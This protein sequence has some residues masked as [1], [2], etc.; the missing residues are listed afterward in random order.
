MKTKL[1]LLLAIALTI[2]IYSFAQAPANDEC[3]GAIS[4]TQNDSCITT[5]GDIDGATE[6][7]WPYC[8]GGI[9]N[10]VWYSFVATTTDPTIQVTGSGDF[11]PVIEMFDTCDGTFL[12]C[13]LTFSGTVILSATGLTIGNSYFVRVYDVWGSPFTT[14][15]DICIYKY[16]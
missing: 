11:L 7:L 8:G 16:Y 15:F 4:L 3:A 6:S 1:T 14:T 13:E 5:A 10:D 2:N 9:A 12:E